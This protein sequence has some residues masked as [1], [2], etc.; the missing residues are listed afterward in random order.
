MV[1]VTTTTAAATALSR[2]CNRSGV[3]CDCLATIAAISNGRGVD[4]TQSKEAQETLTRAL[5][6]LKEDTQSA[7]AAAQ[8]ALLSHPR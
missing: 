1:V 4:D 6:Q 3:F 5:R 8:S 7:T 2:L